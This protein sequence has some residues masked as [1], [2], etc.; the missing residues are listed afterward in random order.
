MSVFGKKSLSVEGAIKRVEPMT[1]SAF[2]PVVQSSAGGAALVTAHPFRWGHAMKILAIMITVAC[3]PWA[4]GAQA[5]TTNGAA[6][7]AL[8]LTS[9]TN[10]AS[11][12][13]AIQVASQL[14]I[15]MM[16]AEAAKFLEGQGISG[17]IRDTNGQVE[18]YSLSVGS[19]HGWT[20][21]YHLAEGCSLGLEMR[22]SAMRPDGL[23]GGNG[24]LEGA[25]IQSNRV[26]II[27]ITLTNRP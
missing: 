17:A 4:A 8:Y 5:T 15:G 27:T 1:S 3:L 7:R 12:S 21:F 19:S 2:T 26:N 6:P 24:L 23:W 13:R 14:R 10:L 16:E 20:T 9:Q 25:V 18:A 22:P 11:V